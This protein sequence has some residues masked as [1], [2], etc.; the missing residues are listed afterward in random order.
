MPNW[1]E[2]DLKIRGS[3]KD[4]VRWCNDNIHIY[5]Y[6]FA[7]G[8]WECSLNTNA[9]KI[10]ADEGEGY[11]EIT[12][13]LQ[14]EAYIEGTSRNFV[15]EDTYYSYCE[16]NNVKLAL[17]IKAAW[18]FESKPFLEMAK[19]YNL[20][21]RF[22]G[23]ECGMQFNREVIIENGELITDNEI[24]YDNYFWECPCPTLGG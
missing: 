23:F 24:K 3:F 20:D 19:K 15:N 22:Y 4:M 13:T 17:H 12:V 10:E 9:V 18:D 7:N 8:E 5:D 16:D 1:C 6:H 14:S 2:G 11:N 21:F